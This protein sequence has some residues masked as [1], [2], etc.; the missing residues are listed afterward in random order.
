MKV[1]IQKDLKSL[2]AVCADRGKVYQIVSTKQIIM[3]CEYPLS[4]PT[5]RI[6]VK[7]G[8]ITTGNIVEVDDREQLI[9]LEA[10]IIIK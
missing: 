5:Q 10:E 4:K 1:T 7:L 2:V 8:N 6:F 9:E 3:C